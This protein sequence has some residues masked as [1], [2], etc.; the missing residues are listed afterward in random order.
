MSKH[1]CEGFP[2]PGL[3]EEPIEISE[4][5]TLAELRKLP[6]EAVIKALNP[7]PATTIVRR[8][9]AFGN[10]FFRPMDFPS[11]GSIVDGHTHNFDHVTWISAGSVKVRAREVN[12]STGE[13][14]GPMVDR[15]Y[16]APAVIC[17]KKNW[18][19]QFT[20]LAA[21]TRADCI[22]ALRDYDGNV[23]DTYDGNLENYS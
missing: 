23:S 22:Y 16:V 8:Y 19:H 10:L 3:P 21:G 14:I 17:I 6:I 9:G 2:A 18:A 15:V 4:T 13:G 20:A 11:V 12:P 5:A 1:T 7:I